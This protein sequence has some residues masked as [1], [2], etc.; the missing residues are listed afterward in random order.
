MAAQRPDLAA[1]QGRVLCTCGERLW[2][3]T[4]VTAHWERGHFDIA[5]TDPCGQGHDWAV[6]VVVALP[7]Y[8]FPQGVAYAIERGTIDSPLDD[9][10]L[11]LSSVFCVRPGCG[12]LASDALAP[13]IAR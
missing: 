6:R 9:V 5:V 4:I 11:P 1:I 12:T 13:V 2:L 10:Q 8:D 7:D 3:S